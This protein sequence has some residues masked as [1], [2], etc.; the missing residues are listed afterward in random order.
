MQHLNN[1]DFF[2][3]AIIIA[4]TILALIRGGV[5]QILSISKWIIALLV[6]KKYNAQIEGLITNL[7]SNNILRSLLA[8]IIA[9]VAT[10]IIITLIKIV[11]DK[12]IKNLGLG[13]MDMFI[14]AIFGFARGVIICG[15]IIMAFEII[16]IDKTH[17]WSQ[18][19]LSPVLKPTVKMLISNLDAFNE[20]ENSIVTTA[21][22]SL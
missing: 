1:Y 22:H 20:L 17:A 4:S 18:S 11:F 3:G 6:T 5:A 7:V 2:F 13:G 14:G 19:L 9:F 12:T 21:N 10:A 8:Y 15:V 16:G